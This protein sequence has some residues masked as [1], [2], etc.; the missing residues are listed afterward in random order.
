MGLDRQQ[1]GQ[2]LTVWLDQGLV[3]GARLGIKIADIAIRLCRDLLFEAG[4]AVWQTIQVDLDGGAAGQL[5]DIG[6]QILRSSVPIGSPAAAPP[7]PSHRSASISLQNYG[8][9]V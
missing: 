8:S 2:D 6:F 3:D 9:V 7:A 4:D 1:R 5:I